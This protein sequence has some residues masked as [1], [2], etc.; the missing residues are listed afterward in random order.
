M[1]QASCWDC[2]TYCKKQ[3]LQANGPLLFVVASAKACVACVQAADITDKALKGT[4]S[5]CREAVDIFLQ[6]IGAEAAAMGLRSMATGGIFIAGGI[7]KRILPMI[8]EGS[9]KEAFLNKQG[10][11]AK[12]IE[13]FPLFVCRKDIGLEGTFQYAL[14]VAQGK[15]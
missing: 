3:A 12:V 11:F 2:A 8:E 10:R 1:M 13:K 5:V 14:S 6:I 7:P 9:L 4:C 15:R